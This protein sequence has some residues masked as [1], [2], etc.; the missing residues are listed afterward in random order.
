[1]ND[2][3]TH[4][5]ST[6]S[7]TYT[8]IYVYLVNHHHHQSACFQREREEWD[9]DPHSGVLQGVF[10]GRVLAGGYDAVKKGAI[11]LGDGLNSWGDRKCPHAHTER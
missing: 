11:V 7:Y 5:R 10:L 6:K 2:T 1:M 3:Q 8:N 9:A 4:T